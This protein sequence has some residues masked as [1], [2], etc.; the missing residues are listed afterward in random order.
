[1]IGTT[2]SHFKITAKLGEGGMGE[3]YRAEDTKLGR[4]VAIKVLPE[5]VATDPERLARFEREA[6]VLASLNHTNIAGI[7]QIEE[8]DGKQLLVMELVE[9]ADLTEYI[10][11]GRIPLSKALPIALQIAEALEAAHEKGIV[12]RDLK[13]ANVKVT[14]DGQVKVLDFG[15]AKA[16]DPETDSQT[17]PS[18]SMSPTLTAQMTQAGVLLGTAA[19]MSPEQA[20]G[21]AVDRRADIWA[22]GVVLME[23]LTGDRVYAGRTVSDT[24]ASVLARE[25]EWENLPEDLPS[26][27]RALL[28]RCLEKE[29]RDRLQAIGEARFVIEKY[30]ED[31]E[32]ERMAAIETAGAEAPA[33]RAKLPWVVAGLVAL[34]ALAVGF[35]GF[36]QLQLVGQ[37]QP[38]VRTSILP[39]EGHDWWLDTVS[40]GRVAISR[41]GRHLAFSAVA[42]GGNTPQL[43]IRPLDSSVGRPVPNTEG[44]AYPF[45]SPDGRHVGFFADRKLKK[46]AVAGGP[47]VTLCEASNG[48]SG[49]WSRQGVIVFAP[50][51]MGEIYRVPAAGGDCVA[52]TQIDSGSGENSHRHPQFLPDDERF[53]YLVRNS[54]GENL[55]R[56]GSVDGSVSRDVISTPT[57]AMFASGRILFTRES[58]LMAQDFDAES[59]ELSGEA[60]PLVENVLQV[61][62]AALAVFSVSEGGNLV[63]QTGDSTANSQLVW[64]DRSGQEI[65]TLGDL[66]D[67]ANIRASRDG[68]WVAAQITGEDIQD[69]IWIYDVSRNLRTRFTFDSRNDVSPSFSPAADRIAFSSENNGAG[70]DIFVKEVGG[71]G[72]AELVYGAPSRK[73]VSSWTPDGEMVLAQEFLPGQRGRI[74]AVPIE[75]GREPMVLIDDGF[76]VGDPT[77][78]PD[79]RW[80]AYTSLESGRREIYVTTF[81]TPG[82]RWQVSTDGGRRPR[83]TRNGEEIIFLTFNRSALMAAQVDG[84]GE[85]FKVGAIAELFDV[86]LRAEPGRV[87]DVTEDG[88]RFI[89]NQAPERGRV[90]ALNLVLN[91]PAILEAR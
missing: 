29:I 68:L 71:T 19:Y 21:E 6:K 7:H 55:I 43:W 81:P 20:R 62:G 28:E 40:P 58:T 65:S 13:P 2:L 87:W 51:N 63:Y 69:D 25:P 15:L 77:V 46:I 60:V 53:L 11:Q 86:E 79:G 35:W 37:P 89:I 27:I 70:L 61:T 59:L 22:F 30:L 26:S 84:T 44:A 76:D 67:Q 50:S 42:E 56:I 34:S 18:I 24:L 8:A 12:H 10:A 91:W 85:T 72:Q 4:E 57:S 52:L 73:F 3:V 23:M 33:S 48:K 78:S 36:A 88:E 75:G 64:L 1:M 80:L 39:P 17:S 45:W 9:G 38:L 41:D 54:G 66:A 74:L 47:P 83:W 31:P 32:A 5:M 82:R 90:S 16:L 49:S 14:P